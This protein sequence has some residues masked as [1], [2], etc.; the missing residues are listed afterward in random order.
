MDK[1]SVRVKKLSSKAKIPRKATQESAGFDLFANNPKDI[2]IKPLERALI[3][4]GIVLEIPPGYEAQIRPRSGLAWKFGITVLNTPGTID[5]DY[6]GEVKVIVINLGE[7]PFRIKK[8]DRIAQ[9]IIT[10]YANC[11]LKESKKLSRTKRQKKGFGH[12]GID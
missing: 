9:M 10:K 6:R 12:T 4:T 7:K 8:Y 3:P 5:P 2:I 1:I 11:E